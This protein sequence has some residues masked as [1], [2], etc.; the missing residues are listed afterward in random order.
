M[1]LGFTLK[2][3]KAYKSPQTGNVSDYPGD[4]SSF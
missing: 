3:S 2:G 4:P 1:E